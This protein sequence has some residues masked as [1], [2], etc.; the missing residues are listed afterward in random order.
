M[1]LVENLQEDVA[2]I[3]DRFKLKLA[4]LVKAIEEPTAFPFIIFL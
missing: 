4:L 2:T 1:G 3:A